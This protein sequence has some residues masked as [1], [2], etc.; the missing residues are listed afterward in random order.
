MK[1]ILVVDNLEKRFNGHNI[2]KGLSFKVFKGEVVS[3]IGPS[4]GGKTTLLRCIDLLEK[5]DKGNIHIG[6]TT[7]TDNTKQHLI[8]Q[9]IGIVFQ[10][11]NL[12]THKTVIENVIEGLLVV[13]KIKKNDA[14]ELGYEMLKKVGVDEKINSYPY[15]LS[16]GQRQ[17]VAIARA[18]VMEP[19]IL[20]VDEITASLDPE[21]VG[22]ILKLLEELAKGETTILNVSHEL[23]FVRDVSTRVLFLNNGIIEAEGAPEY[24]FYQCKHKALVQFIKRFA[25]TPLDPCCNMPNQ[26]LSASYTI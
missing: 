7:V 25:R 22:E 5:I 4:G 14:V 17:R 1:E 19:L 26:N 3:I 16:G 11:L 12:W 9:Q 10:E 13:K 2:L 8:R 15:E 20:L 21:L 6:G 18:F 23:P 24:I